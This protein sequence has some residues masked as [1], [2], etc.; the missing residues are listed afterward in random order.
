MVDDHFVAQ[1]VP[2]K[3]DP[4]ERFADDD[5]LKKVT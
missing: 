3:A 2:R 4:A 5:V 1:D